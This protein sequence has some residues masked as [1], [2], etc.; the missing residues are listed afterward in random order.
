M[1]REGTKDTK[2]SGLMFPNFV[3]FVL[4][5]VCAPCAN[6]SMR[7]IREGGLQTRPLVSQLFF[8]PFA[9]FA[10]FF[11]VAASLR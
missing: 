8:A 7:Q 11:S 10:V 4:V 3:L 5:I 6:S 1:H 2:V 9:F